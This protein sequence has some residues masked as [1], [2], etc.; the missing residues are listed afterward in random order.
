MHMRIARSAGAVR[1]NAGEHRLY[2]GLPGAGHLRAAPVQ[3]GLD[4][5]HRL[6]GRPRARRAEAAWGGEVPRRHF[7]GPRR[8]RAQGRGRRRCSTTPYIS[9]AGERG[10]FVD[11]ERAGAVPRPLGPPRLQ[12]SDARRLRGSRLRGARLLRRD[13]GPIPPEVRVTGGAARSKAL[14]TILGSGPRHPHPHLDARGGRSGRSRHGGRPSR[15]VSRPPRWSS[16]IARWVTPTLAGAALDPDPALADSLRPALPGLCAR[17][18]RPSPPRVA[19]H[20]G[21]AR[22]GGA[23]GRRLD[24]GH[25]P[26]IGHDGGPADDGSRNGRPRGDR[27]RRQRRRNRA[28]RRG[29]RA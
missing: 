22:R 19:R 8:P 5:E 3:H 1:L 29:P 23:R 13:G 28:R 10:P 25:D 2:A 16:C 9:E 15:P 4:A 26:S 12:R 11:A 21:R 7:S 14:R 27:R 20:E 6:A 18:A 17:R 24:P